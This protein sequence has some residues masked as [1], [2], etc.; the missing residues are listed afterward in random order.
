LYKTSGCYIIKHTTCK[1]GVI[2]GDGINYDSIH[3]ILW[4]ITTRGFS[5]DNIVFGCGSGI[6]QQVNR[7]TMK[8]AIKM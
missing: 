8:F 1:V 6:L 5:T 4:N 2:Y 7:D 3:Q